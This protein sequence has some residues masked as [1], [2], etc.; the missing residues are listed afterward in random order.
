[1][2]KFKFEV[3]QTCDGF[4]DP[5]AYDELLAHTP[6]FRGA[7]KVVVHEFESEDEARRRGCCHDDGYGNEVWEK[8]CPEIFKYG[9][10]LGGLDVF[11]IGPLTDEEDEEMKQGFLKVLYHHE[12]VTSAIFMMITNQEPEESLDKPF[13]KEQVMFWQEVEEAVDRYFNALDQAIQN[14]T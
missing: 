12:L 7:A 6:S 3:V 4:P 8:H 9:S 5:M 14:N 1:M 13:K 10:G 11:Y 2:P